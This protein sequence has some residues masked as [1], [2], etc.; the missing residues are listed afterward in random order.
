M[1]RPTRMRRPGEKTEATDPSQRI[2]PSDEMLYRRA[3]LRIAIPLG[4][5]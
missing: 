1:K 4:I 2:I 5:H 3:F